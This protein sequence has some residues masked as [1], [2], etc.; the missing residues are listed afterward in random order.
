MER[1]MDRYKDRWMDVEVMYR[2]I[3]SGLYMLEE[4][5]SDLSWMIENARIVLIH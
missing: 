3:V 5:L 1:R 4:L 2:W